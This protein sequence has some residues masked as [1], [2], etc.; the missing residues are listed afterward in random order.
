MTTVRMK[1]E[2]PAEADTPAATPP[3][4]PRLPKVDVIHGQLRVDDY[5]WLRDKSDPEVAAYLERERF[6][7]AVGVARVA[8]PLPPKTATLRLSLPASESRTLRLT[9]G[10]ESRFLSLSPSKPGPFSVRVHW[11][12]LPGE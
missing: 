7:L 2:S 9:Y 10:T 12:D 5:F 11:G 6:T 3:L 4:A 8:G 1:L